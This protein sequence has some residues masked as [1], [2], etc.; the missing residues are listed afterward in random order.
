MEKSPRNEGIR[1]EGQEPLERGTETAWPQLWTARG[2]IGINRHSGKR[3]EPEQQDQPGRIHRSVFDPMPRGNRMPDGE[4]GRGLKEVFWGTL[5]GFVV[6]AFCVAAVEANLHSTPPKQQSQQGDNNQR[7]AELRARIALLETQS[8]IENNTRNDKQNESSGFLGKFIEFNITDALL[9]LF[10]A[11]LAL[12]TSGLHKETSELRRLTDAQRADTLRSILAAEK[13]ANAAK[14]SAEA[15][16]RLE[17]AYVYI[18][19]IVPQI[20]VIVRGGQDQQLHT[21]ELTI[22]FIN[23]GRTPANIVSVLA[24][25]DFIDHIP[26]EED[27]TRIMKG[28]ATIEIDILIIIGPDKKSSG[29][30]VGIA[31]SLEGENLALYNHGKLSLYCWGHVQYRD[32]FGDIHPTYFCRRSRFDGSALVFDPV[33]GFDRNKSE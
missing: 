5:F 32:I 31:T 27:I 33:G 25:A 28:S 17:R 7:T 2:K 18:D 3:A 4:V 13:A 26:T 14:Q 20:R 9:V 29:V 22:Y 10:T 30:D 21:S 19:T 12:K 15:I 1:D 6:L 11:I 8:K 23:H 16:P 24:L